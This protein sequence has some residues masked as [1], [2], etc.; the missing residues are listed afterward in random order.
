LA[1]VTG[2]ADPVSREQR[3]IKKL[4]ES[5]DVQSNK[6]SNVIVLRFEG[7]SPEHAQMLMRH[8]LVAYQTLYRRVNQ[9]VGSFDFF[10]EQGQLLKQRLDNTA[11]AIKV[12]KNKLGIVSIS[13][14]QAVLQQKLQHVSTDILTH[15]SA[16][17]ASQ[18]R[19]VAL[20]ENLADQPERID[21]S[22]VEGRPNG[23]YD[24]IAAQLFS[25][26]IRER[27]LASK[28]TDGHPVRVA[29]RQQIKDAE[30]IAGNQPS[31]RTETS[32]DTNPTHQ[33]LA[34]DLLLEQAMA[35]SHRSRLM[36]LDQQLV[37]VRDESRK[38]N[39]AELQINDMERTHS[40]YAASYRKYFDHG[41]EARIGLALGAKGTVINRFECG[42]FAR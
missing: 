12:A 3:A 16:L 1:T 5:F 20:R 24:A 33:R 41:E 10:E 26:R 2:L 25:P 11:V 15:Q 29:V 17:A 6:Q 14:Q 35:Q 32:S 38:L 34:L 7:A 39:E 40:M 37:E 28:Y 42:N 9:T 22:V 31:A 21:T 30:M 8:Y 27:E 36:T 13:A 4:Q 19:I 23:A 18:A